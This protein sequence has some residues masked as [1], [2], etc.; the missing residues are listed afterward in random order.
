MTAA[1]YPGGPP[2]VT[3]LDRFEKLKREGWLPS[4]AIE[5]LSLMYMGEHFH[6]PFRP[7]SLGF[8]SGPNG[9]LIVISDAGELDPGKVPTRDPD[10]LLGDPDPVPFKMPAFEPASVAEERDRLLK[11]EMVDT[12][13]QPEQSEHEEASPPSIRDRALA[14][15][16]EKLKHDQ[17]KG[18][19]KTVDAYRRIFMR[20]F[21][22]LRWRDFGP[23]MRDAKQAPGVKPIEPGR[24]PGAKNKI[25]GRKK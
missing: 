21:K 7:G 15:L 22:G 16:V 1:P 11:A 3:L 6:T 24:P 25:R 20:A 10:K 5:I 9:S 12:G 4:Q 13:P 19:V 14:R 18:R 17:A 2:P 8:R 23:I